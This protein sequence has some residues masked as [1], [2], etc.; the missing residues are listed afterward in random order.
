MPISGA[1]SR[2]ANYV[3]ITRDGV[4]VSKDMTLSA[5]NTTASTPLFTLTGAVEVLQLYGIVTTLLS[6]NV[7]AGYL[8]TNDQTAQVDITL[9]TGTT[10]SDFKVG[11]FLTRRSIASVALYG[12]STVSAKVTDPVAATAPD[13]CMPVVIS[14][15]TGGVLTQVEFTYTTT[16]TPASGAITWY[17]RWVPLSVDGN[18]VAA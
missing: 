9:A 5:S 18:L 14:Q 16:N 8:R 3:P 1:F 6:S 15:K 10:L 11:S 17:A 2:D 4:T 7:T 12:T 13:V